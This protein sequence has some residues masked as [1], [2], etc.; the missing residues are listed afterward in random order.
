MEK[1]TRS[2]VMRKDIMKMISRIVMLGDCGER[3][4][5]NLKPW[6]ALFSQK[7]P[8]D[9]RNGS[10]LTGILDKARRELAGLYLATRPVG[11]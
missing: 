3:S 1:R 5:H 7:H 8:K 6:E 11:R 4:R 2:R 10:R 9:M